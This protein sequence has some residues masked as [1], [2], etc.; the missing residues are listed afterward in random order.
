MRR[1]GRARRTIAER[2]RF[3]AQIGHWAH[4]NPATLAADTVGAYFDCDMGA[5]TRATYHAH[6]RAWF[7]FLLRAGL[8]ADDPMLDIRRPRTPRRRPRPIASAHLSALLSSRMHRRTR[9][10]I[11]LA[12]Y[13][14][15]RMHEVAKIRGED[16][17]LV[18]GQLFVIGKGG[19]DEVLPL[20]ELVAAEAAHYPR[21]G[22]WF[23][24]YKDPARAVL[25]NSVSSIVS[26]AMERAG[27]PGTGHS[28]RHWY[29][30]ELLR[31]GADAR[32]TQT[33]MRHASLATTAI[34]TAIDDDQRRAAVLRLPTMR[35]PTAF[36]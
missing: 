6:L 20:H 15:L 28:L 17:D 36:G 24:S 30:T 25:A 18:G 34:Y 35:P 16:V 11:L 7:A 31:A 33:L 1:D 14:G 12:A 5:G 10:M 8:R 4:E 29:A 22:Y 26:R 23:P 9:T 21:R 32:T 3:I 13:E 2:T 27:V 19:V